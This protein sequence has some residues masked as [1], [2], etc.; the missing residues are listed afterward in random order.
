MVKRF[1]GRLIGK[2]SGIK[3]VGTLGR[4][5]GALCA[6]VAFVQVATMNTVM[7]AE[8]VDVPDLGIDWASIGTA[9]ATTLGVVVVGLL[10]VKVA[11]SI[12]NMAIRMFSRMFS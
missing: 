4:A 12:V 3:G 9:A 7:A 6:V 5:V 1:W 8:A 11:I 2:V 10:G